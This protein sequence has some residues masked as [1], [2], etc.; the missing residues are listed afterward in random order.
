MS[1]VTLRIIDGVDRG[2]VYENLST[3]IS[4][5]REAGNSIQLNDDR[6]SRF[7]L[8]IYQDKENLILTDLES[9]NGTLVNGEETHVRILRFGDLI[10]LG[11]STL[12]VGSREQ[13]NAR[14]S[15]LKCGDLEKQLSGSASKDSTAGQPWVHDPNYQWR[16]VERTAPVIPSRLSPGQLAQF[17]EV[18]EYLQLSLRKLIS[19]IEPKN[20]EEPIEMNFAQ[21]Q[22]L[23]D[24][25]AR[26]AEYIRRVGR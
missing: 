13:I 20:S 9:T 4:V 14:L 6:V 25:Q 11:R 26:L 22:N 24:L 18:I 16:L 1:T 2:R 10:R 5:G 23:L 7:H 3:P 17:L 21:W 12:L 19:E 8:K 15:Q